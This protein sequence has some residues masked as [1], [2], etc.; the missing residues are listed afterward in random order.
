M[1][2]I[3]EV[4]IGGGSAREGLIA[5]DVSAASFGEVLCAPFGVGEVQLWF[6]LV[7]WSLMV[8]NSEAGLRQLGFL[9]PL[10]AAG[11]ASCFV[12]SDLFVKALVIVLP[13]VKRPLITW[14]VL[15]VSSAFTCPLTP[16][17]GFHNLDFDL[18]FSE[19]TNVEMV[20]GRVIDRL[21]DVAVRSSRFLFGSWRH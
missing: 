9:W 14:L 20:L 18:W 8:F 16:V 13:G 12:I 5:G 10:E 7:R 11:L 6:S 17:H 4:L 3:I 1:Q 19:I 2:D 15:L 21:R